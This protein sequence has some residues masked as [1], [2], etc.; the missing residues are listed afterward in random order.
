MYPVSLLIDT[1]GSEPQIVTVQMAQTADIQKAAKWKLPRSLQI[2]PARP[3]EMA[4]IITKVN[5]NLEFARLAAKRWRHYVETGTAATSLKELVLL[6]A[7]DAE[8]EFCFF[9]KL[10]APWFPKGI[11]GQVMLRRT[12]CHHLFMD[13]LYQD[14]PIVAGESSVKKGVGYALL[15]SVAALARTLQTPVL[16]GEATKA[17]APWYQR[18]FGC[19][20][21]DHFIV[22]GPLLQELAGRFDRFA[23]LAEEAGA[24]D[25]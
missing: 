10:T 17:S 14:P 18:Q 9:L 12:W 22:Q 1:G 21:K 19:E 8:G 5:D 16:W 7:G 25:A 3:E 20:V 6:M 11:L 23:A 13:F 15:V 2:P 4:D 24:A